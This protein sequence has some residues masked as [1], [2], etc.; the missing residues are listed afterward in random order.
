LVLTVD[1]N[2][3]GE[4]GLNVQSGIQATFTL[5]LSYESSVL[6]F[7]INGEVTIIDPSQN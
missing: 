4:D 2:L 7:G 3:S 1:V 5:A 6:Y